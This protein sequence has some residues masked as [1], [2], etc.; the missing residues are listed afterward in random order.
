MHNQQGFERYR[1]TSSLIQGKLTS[2]YP[3]ELAVAQGKSIQEAIFSGTQRRI[4]LTAS[5]HPLTKPCF[6]SASIA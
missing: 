4:R 6:S 3:G 5:D 2:E 1:K